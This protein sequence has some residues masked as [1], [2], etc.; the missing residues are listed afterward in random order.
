MRLV[1][2]LGHIIVVAVVAVTSAKAGNLVPAPTARAADRLP[3]YYDPFRTPTRDRLP[4][5]YINGKPYWAPEPKTKSATSA[6]AADMLPGGYDPFRPPKL[7]RLPDDYVD[8]K[9]YWAPAPE[10]KR[11]PSGL[12]VYPSWEAE[13]GARYF[14]SSGT[15]RLDLFGNPPGI[16]T[17]LNSRLTY[18]NLMAHAGEVFGRVDHATGLFAKGYVGGGV[19]PG[20]TLQDE[21]FPPAILPYSSTDSAQRNGRLAYGTIDFGWA[22]RTRTFRASF[23]AGYLHYSE[24]VHAFG[25]TQTAANPFICAPGDVNP[26]TQVIRQDTNW[27]AI[28]L[29]VGTEWRMTDRWKLATEVAWLPYVSL[30]AKDT[31]FLRIGCDLC[32]LS[33]PGKENGVD[34]LM[35]VQLEAILSYTLTDAFSVGLG[36]RY[37][38]FHTQPGN[39]TV[40]FPSIFAPVPLAATLKTE[41]WGAFFQGSYKFGQLQPSAL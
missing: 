25:C 41:R 23:F 2:G 22:W 38:N 32:D 28:R 12:V 34:A 40:H 29:G 21:D 31:H 16:T 3:D 20:G 14:V 5:D 27:D 35:S 18:R 39:T 33:G 19:I 24:S 8:G 7:D 11:L 30:T 36:G 26:S 10:M 13:F 6:M 9:P 1:H 15:T 17:Q 37:W 4:D